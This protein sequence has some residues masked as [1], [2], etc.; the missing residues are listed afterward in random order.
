MES[1]LHALCGGCSR[2][3]IEATPCGISTGRMTPHVTVV[4]GRPQPP[5]PPRTSASAAG[6]R[7]S[8]RLP[9]PT[10]AAPRAPPPESVRR[11]RSG[12]APRRPVA[13]LRLAAADLRRRRSLPRSAAASAFRAPGSGRRRSI[14]PSSSLLRPSPSSPDSGSLAPAGEPRLPRRPGPDPIGTSKG[15][16]SPPLIFP[17]SP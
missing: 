6:H 12:A 2:F 16:T 13:G 4:R 7:P 3:N 9:R 14:R 17:L 1:W 8:D 15:L 10:R 11:R 5:P